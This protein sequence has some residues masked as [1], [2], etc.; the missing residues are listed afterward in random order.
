MTVCSVSVS[1]EFAPVT[2]EL[3]EHWSNSFR[4]CFPR[5][6]GA[7][8]ILP[9]G[10][11]ELVLTGMEIEH[12]SLDL[13][14]LGLK[15]DG[16]PLILARGGYS[17]EFNFAKS[18]VM[19]I[20]G[21]DEIEIQ[22][23]MPG[24][25]RYAISRYSLNLEEARLEPMSHYTVD[26]SLTALE[27]ADSLLADGNI[28]EA[29]ETILSIFYP[30]SYYSND[31]MIARLL[32]A[33]NRTALERGS[34]NQYRDGVEL[35]G[36][37]QRFIYAHSDKPWY[38]AFRDSSDFTG[39]SYSRYMGLNEYAMIMNNYAYF[40]EQSGELTEALV[41]LE[42]VLELDPSRMVAHLN[43]ADV[44]WGLDR[45]AEA[46]EYYATYRD[47]MKERNL[48]HQIP[49]RVHGRIGA[50]PADAAVSDCRGSS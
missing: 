9:V 24:C 34:R 50:L 17:G 19:Y 41:V 12:D 35:F 39:S 36:N 14:L 28:A 26:P 15:D 43:I 44:L 45:P 6:C 48:E 11:E 30:G 7:D 5:V 33:I 21:D 18:A 22:F 16:V 32:R 49:E 4:C 37:L 1:G 27:R 13:Y 46:A 29:V 31:E 23:Q 3:L 40:L 38:L 8:E 10:F 25:A 47:E 2:G 42:K 20:E